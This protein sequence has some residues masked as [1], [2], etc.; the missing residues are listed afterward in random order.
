MI[1]TSIPARELR[2]DHFL[3]VLQRFNFSLNHDLKV[4]ANTRRVAVEIVRRIAVYVTLRM[5]PHC[6]IDPCCELFQFIAHV[7][8]PSANP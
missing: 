7:S 4:I 3:D 1:R 5:T 2:A 6:I 8:S